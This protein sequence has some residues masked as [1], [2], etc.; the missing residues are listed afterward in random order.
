MSTGRFCWHD[1]M[2]MEAEKGRA[3]YGEL[4]GWTFEEMDMGNESP[5]IM[6]NDGTEGTGGI[7]QM[8]EDDQ[9]PPHWMLYVTVEDCEGL[10]DVIGR[11]RPR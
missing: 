11:D 9:V 2:T 3:F 8:S 7:V 5:Y 10:L 1:L 6:I 4:L